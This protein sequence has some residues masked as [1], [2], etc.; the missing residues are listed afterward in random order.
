MPLPHDLCARVQNGFHAR[1]RRIAV[2]HTVQNLG[3]LSVLLREG[4]LSSVTRGTAAA[5]DPEAWHNVKSESHRRIWAELKYRDDRAVLTQ[6][7]LI[8]MPSKRII[9]EP[10][11]VRA[12]CSGRRAQFI[13]PLGMGEIAVVRTRNKE[14]LE[15]REAV[16]LNL[17]GEVVCRAI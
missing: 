4:F 1:L 7:R 11:E 5:P 2:P 8:S 15:A 13:A 10:S 12:L 16:R 14:W 3:I 6:M 17:G 9:M